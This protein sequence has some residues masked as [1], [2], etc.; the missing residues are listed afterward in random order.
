MSFAEME[1]IGFLDAL[2]DRQTLMDTGYAL[3]GGAAGGVGFARLLELEFFTKEE[4]GKETTA[5][6][7]R[8]GAGLAVAAVGGVALTRLSGP[9]AQGFVG[10]V[11]SEI[12]K[13]LW[14]KFAKREEAQTAPV[15]G[16]L[17][18]SAS[19]YVQ[20]ESARAYSG[21]SLPANVGGFHGGLSRVSV[22][23]PDPAEL[24]SLM[25]YAA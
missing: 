8:L 14:A 18:D 23:T 9:A 19:S 17:G 21:D 10:G 16:W 7:K 2:V 12:G 5:L 3:A 4:P 13:M 22:S 1:D 24:A 25:S 20:L 6:L 11:G 15:A